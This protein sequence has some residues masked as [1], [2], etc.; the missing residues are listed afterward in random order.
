MKPRKLISTIAIAVFAAL[1]IPLDLAA[2]DDNVRPCNQSM[3]EG[4]VPS[5]DISPSV[6]QSDSTAT[7]S[8][9]SFRAENDLLMASLRVKDEATGILLTVAT[10][11]TAP[12]VQLSP[13]NL[14]FLCHR[15]DLLPICVCTPPQTITVTNLGPTVLNITDI[16]NTGHFS[17][18]HTCG[19]TLGVGKSCAI[20]VTWL[21]WT[22]PTI[23]G[24]GHVSIYD[25]GVG[26]PQTAG[27]FGLKQ[28]TPH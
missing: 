17:Q 21:W 18:T 26:S 10:S 11:G 6:P 4:S 5:T 24:S 12:T 1:L 25:N 2:Q 19:P 15:I 9:L 23:A 28:C 7:Q 3:V 16:T 20:S 8:D 27:L 13:T 22:Q 14:T